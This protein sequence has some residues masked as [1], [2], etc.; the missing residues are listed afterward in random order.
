[1]HGPLPAPSAI[2]RW[3][4][5]RGIELL[6]DRRKSRPAMALFWA[7]RGNANL[8]CKCEKD[9]CSRCPSNKKGTPRRAGRLAK[10]ERCPTPPTVCTC[11]RVRMY[12]SPL[13]LLELL[14]GWATINYT[15]RRPHRNVPVQTNSRNRLS[16]PLLSQPPTITTVDPVGAPSLPLLSA[17]VYGP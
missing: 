13:Y 14:V 11:T 6:P 17:S 2:G 10:Q 1:V 8:C 3:L 9:R 5:G 12:L 7:R 16:L 4:A 15:G